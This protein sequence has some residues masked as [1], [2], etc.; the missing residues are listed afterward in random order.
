MPNKLYLVRWDN[1]GMEIV[2]AADEEELFGVLDEMDDP[3]QALFRPYNGS[4]RINL[5]ASS[6]TGA[7]E[8]L[9]SGDYSDTRNL[10]EQAIREAAFPEL[11]KRL[12]AE[13]GKEAPQKDGQYQ[14]EIDA[15]L[16]A[17]FSKKRTPGWRSFND[18]NART[19]EPIGSVLK[20]NRP[21]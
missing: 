1:G 6:R 18:E 2:T 4:I 19:P 14:S 13:V 20:K 3:F 15:D 21:A 12:E 17:L 11:V 8:E 10:M 16:T 5:V 7:I 9:Y